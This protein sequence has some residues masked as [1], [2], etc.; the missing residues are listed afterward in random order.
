M[1]TRKD[2]QQF[3]DEE[4]AQSQREIDS[5]RKLSIKE[6]VKAR[7]AI[8]GLRYDRNYSKSS[9]DYGLCRF[10]V[11]TNHSSL[12]VG[13]AVLV[14]GYEATIWDYDNEENLIIGF[15]GRAGI[16]MHCFDD[17]KEVVVEKQYGNFLASSYRRF[18]LDLPSEDSPFWNS[19][20]IPSKQDVV[21]DVDVDVWKQHIQTVEQEL[22][23]TLLES[24]REAIAR[25]FAAKDYYMLQ[26]PPGTGK[27]FVIALIA[28]IL[29]FELGERVCI[30]GPN[31][32]AI[33]NALVKIGEILPSHVEGILKVGYPFQTAGLSF[34]SGDKTLTINNISCYLDVGRV[35]ELTNLVMGMTPYTFYSSRAE[36]IKFDTVIIDESGQMSIPVAMMA[37]FNCKK[38]IL[39]GDHKQL[40]P[41]IKAENIVEPLKQSV[42][43]YMLSEKNC[44]M[45]DTSF[46][47]NGPICEVVSDL[48]YD[49]KLKSYNPDKRLS[50]DIDSEY[51][52]GDYSIIAKNISGNG[53]QSSTC[54][55][56]EVDAIIREYFSAGFSCNRIG[57]L[58]PFRAQCSEIRRKLFK[59]DMIA[60]EYKRGIVVDT[61]DKLQGQERE[62]IIISLTS[63]NID[64]INE[65]SD[66]LYNP[67]KLNVAL[68]R[69]KCKL[70]ILGNFEAISTM[71]GFEGSYM[72]KLLAHP[73]VKVIYQ[74]NI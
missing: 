69:A 22:G 25:A 1:I 26:G 19:S 65:L 48:F 18:M 59:D 73:N 10:I 41:I 30:T 14:N 9:G 47:M 11:D 3:I 23:M 37:A 66:F 58:A 50:I 24:Q 8:V 67:N 72:Q 32:M 57:V 68:S 7:K 56:V 43:N 20:I 5:Y 36:G 17:G 64:Y 39:C 29:A 45:I 44:M 31:Y 55:A 70:I 35:N 6:K 63:G 53:R 28:I 13:D 16:P 54:E 42:F 61:I 74:G 33:N 71:D 52:S 2:L 60:D 62:V 51:L 38:L 21:F 15:W 27:S 40:T 34:V 46:R 49:G 12:G 4:H